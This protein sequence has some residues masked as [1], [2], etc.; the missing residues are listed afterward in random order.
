[1]K[2][3]TKGETS[4]WIVQATYKPLHFYTHVGLARPIEWK[5]LKTHSALCR[6][7]KLPQ[8]PCELHS[9]WRHS[10]HRSQIK[11]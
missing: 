4:A 9:R 10:L 2:Y 3:Y 5:H 1:M 7:P 6:S 8:D 11:K